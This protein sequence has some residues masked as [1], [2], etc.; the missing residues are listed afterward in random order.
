MKGK[1]KP[2]KSISLFLSLPF[3]IIFDWEIQAKSIEISPKIALEALKMALPS[4]MVQNGFEPQKKKKLEIPSLKSTEST[5]DL[6]FNWVIQA[7]EEIDRRSMTSFFVSA[8]VLIA[9][10]KLF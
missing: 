3:K 6:I 10:K 9:L 8:K 5:K 4:Q 2:K 1:K 7:Y